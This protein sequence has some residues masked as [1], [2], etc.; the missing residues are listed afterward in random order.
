[1]IKKEKYYYKPG[2]ENT[3]CSNNKEKS[4][5]LFFKF[6]FQVLCLDKV[7]FKNQ[8]IP[9]VSNSWWKCLLNVAAAKKKG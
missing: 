7:F 9:H 3:C 4:K 2:T 5:K 1:M 8:R 6:K